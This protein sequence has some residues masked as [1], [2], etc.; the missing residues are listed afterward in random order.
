MGRY[1][2][3]FSL[4]GMLVILT[5]LVYSAAIF[6]TIDPQNNGFLEHI[7]YEDVTIGKPFV[8]M[9]FWHN[10]GSIECN[11][12]GRLDI[13]E[14]GELIQTRWSNEINMMP[15][16]YRRLDVY[17][18][19]E[20]VSANFTGAVTVYSCNRIFEF[21]TIDFFMNNT[22][23]ERLEEGN[24]TIK[25][26]NT[27]SY[28][29]H[30][31]MR[32]EAVEDIE[33]ILI[34][35]KSPPPEWIVETAMV[36]RMEKGEVFDVRINYT[37][38]VW[39][40]NMLDFEIIDFETGNVLESFDIRIDEKQERKEK[41]INNVIFIFSGFAI[42]FAIMPLVLALKKRRSSFRYEKLKSSAKRKLEK[43][44]RVREQFKKE[45]K[46]S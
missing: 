14:N 33:N 31:L 35:S 7:Q 18:Y 29:D 17:Y 12:R 11:V 37:P 20:N 2:F 39:C 46:K 36:E 43:A 16:S 23:L 40:E 38:S 25:V 41:I 28:K 21:E 19:P 1:M 15:G 45:H 10:I 13:S 27:K 4:L 24:E 44:S 30:V 8:L 42:G 26:L 34:Y 5:G 6:V 9:L 22:V 32:L 3:R